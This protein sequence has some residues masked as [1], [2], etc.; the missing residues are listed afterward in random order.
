MNNQGFGRNRIKSSVT[1]KSEAKVY[2]WNMNG[3]TVEAFLFYVN[4]YHGYPLERILS[5]TDKM[6]SASFLSHPVVA[7]WAHKMATVLGMKATHGINI[8][9]QLPRLNWLTLLMSVKS[10]NSEDQH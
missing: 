9:F 1:R 3:K 2:E 10:A 4:T 5:M 8:D 6:M 7:Q